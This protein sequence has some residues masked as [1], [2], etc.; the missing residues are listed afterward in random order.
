[1]TKKESKEK[2]KEKSQVIELQK[3]KTNRL[4]IR[5]KGLSPLICHNWAH[6]AKQE[7]L[8]KQMK[9]PKAAKSAR[10]PWLDYCECFYWLSKKPYP[11]D[12]LPLPNDENYPIEEDIKNAV[13]GFPCVAVKKAMVTAVTSMSNITKIA[14]RQAFH[15]V[16]EYFTIETDEMPVMHEDMVRLS[17]IGSTA[18]LR[19][20]PYFHNWGG[21]ITIDVN[22]NV[23][24][25]EQTVHLLH[26]AGFSVGLGDWR[27]TK[28][29]IFGRFEVVD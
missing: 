14:A 12:P 22:I 25:A 2:G 29:G 21:Q 7:I 15:V 8:D 26:L 13:F 19:Y 9:K 27:P 11:V 17:G 5:I 18:D 6:K 20:R 1:M 23:I 3:L 10:D 28:D 16:G 24:S 4:T